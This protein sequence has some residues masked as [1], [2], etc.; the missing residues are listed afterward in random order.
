MST[1]TRCESVPTSGLGSSCRYPAPSPR[2]PQLT[3]G[4]CCPQLAGG[5]AVCG[6]W[7]CD[8]TPKSSVTKLASG[9]LRIWARNHES[10]SGKNHPHTPAPPSHWKQLSRPKWGARSPTSL[11]AESSSHTQ[12]ARI[13]E[14]VHWQHWSPQTFFHFHTLTRSVESFHDRAPSVFFGNGCVVTE[15]PRISLATLELAVWAEE[16]QLERL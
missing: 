8:V 16:A 10:N 6:K 15:S 9:W 5:E 12:P 2:S 3:A 1:F 11:S 13:A 4:S 14:A 7:G